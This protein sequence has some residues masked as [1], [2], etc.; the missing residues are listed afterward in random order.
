MEEITQII[1]VPEHEQRFGIDKQTTDM[2]N[3]L[4]SHI[5]NSKRTPSVLN[6][7]HRLIERYKQLREE[8]SNFDKNNNALLPK[9]KGATFKPLVESLKQLN[10]KLYWLLPVSINN[11]KV[12]DT[13][14]EDEELSFINELSLAQV[15]IEQAEYS[16]QWLANTVPEEQNKY[17]HYLHQLNRLATPFTNQNLENYITSKPVHANLITIVDTLNDQNSY[18]AKEDVIK[19][20]RFVSQIY[21]I[22]LSCLESEV[23]EN[24][25]IINKPVPLTANDTILLK[26]FITLPLSVYKFS[27][28]NLPSTNIMTRSDLN[29]HFINYWKF[30]KNTTTVNTWIVEDLEKP[31]EFESDDFL[32][33][34]KEF[35]LDESLDKT[36]DDLYEKYLNAFIPKT[37]IIFGLIK[38]YIKGGL[39]LFKIVKYLEPFMIYHSDLSFK[40]YEEMIKFLENRIHQ[41]K[42]QFIVNNNNFQ[43][44]YNKLYGRTP[45]I[46]DSTYILFNI[47]SSN[48]VM[49][50]DVL[51]AYNISEA[52]KTNMSNDEILDK[53]IRID[54]ARLF[55]SAISKITLDLMVSNVLDKFTEIESQIEE[56]KIL[57]FLQKLCV[58]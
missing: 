32:N 12:Y 41:Y 15:L 37:R 26:S 35:I 48:E 58:K 55:M 33:N 36:Q 53:M 42:K 4:L 13:I 11:K 50:T 5:P 46:A 57:R 29:M 17:I 22:G 3:E 24:R 25:K 45:K 40:Q 19:Q 6:S 34:I 38:N 47:L 39:S 2:L 30:L 54:Y 27:H 21:N 7:I 9:T 20:T 10:Q 16:D 23:N 18:V 28:I 43:A 8:F 31:L 44:L 49:K 51:K 14:N 52:N 1:D 56:K